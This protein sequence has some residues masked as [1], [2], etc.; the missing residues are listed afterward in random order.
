MTTDPIKMIEM[1]GS[2]VDEVLHSWFSRHARP[3]PL[4]PMAEYH[5]GWRDENLHPTRAPQGKMLRPL[6]CLL[7]FQVF[8]PDWEKAL[9][10]AAACELYHN[11]T[12][13]FDDMQ[14]GDKLRRGRP[15]VWSLWGIGQGIN[16]GLLLGYLSHEFILH[17]EEKKFSQEKILALL[18]A[19]TKMTLELAEGQSMDLDF[20]TRQNVSMEEYLEMIGKKT[21]ALIS[22]CTYGGALLAQENHAVASKFQAFGYKLGVAMQ[23]RDDLVGIWGGSLQSGKE[24]AKDVWRRKKS[25]PVL[26]AFHTLQGE[27][28]QRLL[29]YYQ[30]FEEPNEKTVEQTVLLL[31][32]GGGRQEGMALASS[33]LEEAFKLLRSTQI[34]PEKL[35]ALENFAHHAYQAIGTLRQPIQQ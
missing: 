1:Y 9:D 7:S 6:L 29:H 13:V 12:L 19:Y 31:E 33:L 2:R 21:G 26:K 20:E 15:T 16:T 23:I 34:P 25:F 18:H 32:E 17:L 10:F 24:M 27:K 3:I 5:M 8:N 35:A 4:Y 22:L 30:G 11:H 28:R 14:D